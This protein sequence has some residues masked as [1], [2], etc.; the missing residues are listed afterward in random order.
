MTVKVDEPR[1]HQLARDIDRLGRG[2]WEVRSH[3]R[4]AAA[5]EGHVHDAVEPAPGIEH[6]AAAEQQVQLGHL[7]HFLRD[8]GVP[9]EQ[10]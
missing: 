10:R 3:R 9:V 2:P 5:R 7:A 8:G 4:D 1:R 6:G